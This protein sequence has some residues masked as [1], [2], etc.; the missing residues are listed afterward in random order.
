MGCVI[1]ADPSQQNTIAAV[2]IMCLQTELTTDRREEHTALLVQQAG[3]WCTAMETP[4]SKGTL[5]QA[6]EH[7][8]RSALEQSV[9]GAEAATQHELADQGG[10]ARP[11]SAQHTMVSG[12]EQASSAILSL[13]TST[14]DC[15]EQVAHVT[16]AKGGPA[17]T[18]PDVPPTSFSGAPTDSACDMAIALQQLDY[19]YQ[20]A[21][22]DLDGRTARIT[23]TVRTAE[24]QPASSAPS[25][26]ATSE[27]EEGPTGHNASAGRLTASTG[28][29]VPFQV[30]SVKD[31]MRQ[32]NARGRTPSSTGSSGSLFQLNGKWCGW[33]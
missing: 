7:A 26:A 20:P 17:D 8:I 29:S 23:K 25:I 30:K 2:P 18:S 11:A 3:T 15:A 22:V 31:L 9:P 21:S 4:C 24:S 13:A 27:C 5:Q 33:S 28:R 10:D 16:T 12:S 6:I 32:R 14:S 19:C 1:A